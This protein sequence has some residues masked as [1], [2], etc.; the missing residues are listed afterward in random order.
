[1]GNEARSPSLAEVEA[2]LASATGEIAK[3]DSEIAPRLERRARLESQVALLEKLRLTFTG[4]VAPPD[5]PPIKF[6]REDG[7]AQPAIGTAGPRGTI[8]AYVI[9]HAKRIL[10]EHDGPMHINELYATFL[11]RGYT[12]PGAGTAANLTAHLTRS[13]AIESPKRGLYC[14][15]TNTGRRFQ[16]GDSH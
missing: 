5:S 15:P 10:Q 2:W 7:A 16:S 13:D 11:K 4:D 8:G 3:V 9:E 12:V 14:L 6:F 1:V